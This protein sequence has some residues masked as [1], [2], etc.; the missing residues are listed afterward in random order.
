M[1]NIYFSC[2]TKPSNVRIMVGSN[3]LMKPGKIYQVEKI[4]LNDFNMFKKAGDLALIKSFD[5]IQF[6]NFVQ[7]INITS[8]NYDEA[9]YPV[10]LTGW[11]L[12]VRF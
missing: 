5:D 7:P 4:I 6:N 10:V 2:R 8:K 3:S 9:G 12:N 1:S 11:G